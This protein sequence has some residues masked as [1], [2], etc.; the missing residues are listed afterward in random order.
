[1]LIH[2]CSFGLIIEKSN[3]KMCETV[4]TRRRANTKLNFK[5]QKECC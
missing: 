1:M 3:G 5:I 4:L 2:M